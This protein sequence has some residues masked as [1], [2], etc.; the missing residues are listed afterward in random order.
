MMDL[1]KRQRMQARLP[2]VQAVQEAVKAYLKSRTSKS[3]NRIPD[4]QALLLLQSYE[5]ILGQNSDAAEADADAQKSAP[6]DTELCSAALWSMSNEVAPAHLKLARLL[7]N[8]KRQYAPVTMLSIELR[9]LVRMACGLDKAAEALHVLEEGRRHTELPPPQTK[10]RTLL[11][12]AYGLVLEAYSR[13]SDKSGLL[14]T[15]N[16]GKWF[17]FDATTEAAIS[18]VIFYSNH[19]DPANLEKWVMRLSSSKSDEQD[20]SVFAEPLRAALDYC[21]RSKRLD[22]G[23]GFVRAMMTSN[24]CKPVWDE[25]LVWGFLLQKSVDEVNRM[26]NVMVQSNKGLAKDRSQRRLPDTSTIN[27]LV[28]TAIADKDPYVAERLIATGKERGIEPDA[29]TLTLQMQYRLDVKDVDGALIAY[30]H[31]QSKDLSSNDDVPA[32]NRLL[33]ALCTSGRHDFDTIMNVAADL[34]DRRAIFEPSTV[35]TLAV[36]H[37]ERDEVQDVQD[38]IRTHAHGYSSAD[39]ADLRTAIKD[40]C[41]KKTTPV[42]SLWD[43][44]HILRQDFDEMP[45]EDRTQIMQACFDRNRA[46]MAL[47]VFSH[48]RAHSRDDTIPDA[49]TYLAA[50]LGAGQIKDG[51]CLRALH[52]QM[53][54]DTTVNVTTRMLNGLMIAYTDC[55]QGEEA[56]DIWDDISASQE[57]PT[58]NS[59]QIAFRVC[60]KTSFADVKAQEIWSRLRRNGVEVDQSLWAAYIAA[61][62][63][64]G[65]VNNAVTTLEQ[66]YQKDEV[67][68]DPL[69]LGSLYNAAILSHKHPLVAMWASKEHSEA[70]AKL[71]EVGLAFGEY[72]FKSYQVD[73]SVKP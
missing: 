15:L 17:D 28:E 34:S 60:E 25:I 32:V 21:W 7:Y 23:H 45:R 13:K 42:A 9:A 69:M 54:I 39:R 24:P 8:T 51:K 58:Y 49:D 65:D 29:R 31:L 16:A 52:N 4:T 72:R 20:Q 1:V 57:G 63:G 26:M 19:E 64:N 71:Q 68:L 48:M 22:L 62:V 2:E 3:S 67:E 50:F 47:H 30:K 10:D 53:K 73:R 36:L 61:L 40:F 41:L 59:I 38:L 27:R 55:Q 43:A 33:V 66:A 70:W 56:L 5:Y 18:M 14:K 6:I 12:Y 37:L 11:A 46:D 35:Q 44:Y